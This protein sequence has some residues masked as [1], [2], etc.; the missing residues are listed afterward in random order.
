M[1]DR[2]FLDDDGVAARMHNGLRILEGAGFS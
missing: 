1:A 2:G